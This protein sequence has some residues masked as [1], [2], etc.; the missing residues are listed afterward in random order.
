MTTVTTTCVE[1]GAAFQYERAVRGRPRLTCG[2][3]CRS[4]RNERTTKLSH[5]RTLTMPVN[6]AALA[7]VQRVLAEVVKQVRVRQQAATE[8]VEQAV[9]GLRP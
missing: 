9:A 6:P 3:A 8:A 5:L 7:E 2:Q 4:K 1:C